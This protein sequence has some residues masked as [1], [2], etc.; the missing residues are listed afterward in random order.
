MT[1]LA[2]AGISVGRDKANTTSFLFDLLDYRI[3]VL[4]YCLVN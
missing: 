3:D 2:I 4:L 1:S